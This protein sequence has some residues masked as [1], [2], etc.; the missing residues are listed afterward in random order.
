MPP[1]SS[2]T[3]PS[4]SGHAQPNGHAQPR[5]Q[6]HAPT[7]SASG[8]HRIPK[9]F[10]LVEILIV[11][12]LMAFLAIA[13]L[14][15]TINSQRQY[16]FMTMFKEVMAKIREPRM[17]AITN[18]TVPDIYNSLGIIPAPLT[19]PLYIPPQY[20]FHITRYTEYDGTG[21]KITKDEYR[22][23][24]F[25]DQEGTDAGTEGKFDATKD[26]IT[27][28]TYTI[29]AMKYGLEIYT[30]NDLSTGDMIHPK[31]ISPG[32]PGAHDSSDYIT[33]FYQSPFASFSADYSIS[34]QTPDQHSLYLKLY[35]LR[36]PRIYRYIAVFESGIA[37]AFYESALTNI[38]NP[39]TPSP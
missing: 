12:A 7:R 36:D 31:T 29:D 28:N 8:T 6:A 1:M 2:K 30:R 18:V 9:G 13:G 15:N 39:I 20:G 10:T 27:G 38:I 4:K 24:I 17:Y 37:E 14:S 33:L 35:D 19:P 25:A 11:I 23:T 22:I 32:T 16:S 26:Y 3:S 34:P 21:T 5:N